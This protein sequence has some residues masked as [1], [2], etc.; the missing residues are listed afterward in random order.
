MTHI[1]FIFGLQLNTDQQNYDFRNNENHMKRN[2]DFDAFCTLNCGFR[3]INRIY[4]KLRCLII[5]YLC[6]K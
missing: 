2:H 6:A 3:K 1:S 5:T 4:D